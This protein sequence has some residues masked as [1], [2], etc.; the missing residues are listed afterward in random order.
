MTAGSQHACEPTGRIAG[1]PS[2]PEP[3]VLHSPPTRSICLQPLCPRPR[4]KDTFHFWPQEMEPIIFRLR[5]PRYF[6][7]IMYS[8][9]ISLDRK[10]WKRE[11][12]LIVTHSRCFQGCG[13][14][15]NTRKSQHRGDFLA[16]VYCFTAS[17]TS[18][19]C[20]S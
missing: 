18:C 14:L 20:P 17:V 7:Y 12:L 6:A 19:F 1:G 8:Q 13:A 3:L 5:S 15:A 11:P 9:D 16:L 2:Q 4:T 10:P